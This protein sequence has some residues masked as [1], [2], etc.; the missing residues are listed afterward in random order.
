[1]SAISQYS[2]YSQFKNVDSKVNAMIAFDK[3][4]NVGQIIGSDGSNG[5]IWTDSDPSSASFWSEF[6]ATQAVNINDNNVDNVNTIELVNIIDSSGSS[7]TD[8]QLLS[9]DA[10]G[11]KWIDQSDVI[12]KWSEFPAT[13][14]ID[15][16]GNDISD[17][18]TLYVNTLI[19]NDTNKVNL[20]MVDN[21]LRFANGSQNSDFSYNTIVLRNNANS[22]NVS[23]QNN[24]IR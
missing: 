18:G 17:V 24:N 5:L 1:M 3:S 4:G 8:T 2:N 21:K 6:P 22:D 20:D 15:A 14:T 13:Q 10:V 19:K 9:Q 23:I 16:S 11:A 7:G 12:E